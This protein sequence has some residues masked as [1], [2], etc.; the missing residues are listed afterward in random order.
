MNHPKQ[1]QGKELQEDFRTIA[2]S[3]QMLREDAGAGREGR[4]EFR[5]F[6][7]QYRMP[8]IIIDRNQCSLT[9][10]LPPD[11]APESLRIEAARDTDGKGLLASCVAH[12]DR[13]WEISRAEASLP[14]AGSH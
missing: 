9:V 13:M 14:D 2:R 4:I 3:E 1:W 10:R 7:T 6:N 12:W 8:M 11:E 5:H